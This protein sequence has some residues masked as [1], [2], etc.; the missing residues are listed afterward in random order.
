MQACGFSGSGTETVLTTV[1]Q[2]LLEIVCPIEFGEELIFDGAGGKSEG[3]DSVGG[4]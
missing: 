3:G 1:K 2:A 4:K